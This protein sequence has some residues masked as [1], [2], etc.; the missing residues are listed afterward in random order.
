MLA[1]LD[2]RIRACTISTVTAEMIE[3]RTVGWCARS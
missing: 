2:G 1:M 3:E